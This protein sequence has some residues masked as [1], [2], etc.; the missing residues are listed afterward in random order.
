MADCESTSIKF[1]GNEVKVTKSLVGIVVVF[2]D[3]AITFFFWCSMIALNQLQDAT[4]NEV[5][6][7]VVQS[8]DYT[9]MITQRSHLEKTEDLPGIYYAWCENINA[10]EAEQYQCPNYEEV[11]EN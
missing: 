1:G 9:V 8:Q 2:F 4:E 11:D 5:N 3:L 10:H 7:G 6:Q